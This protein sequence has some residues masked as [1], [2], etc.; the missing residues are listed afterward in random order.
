MSIVDLE[1]ELCY[2]LRD[3]YD[4]TLKSIECLDKQITIREKLWDMRR[5]VK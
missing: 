3:T 1:I 2:L 5:K 4:R